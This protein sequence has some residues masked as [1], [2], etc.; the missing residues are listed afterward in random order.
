MTPCPDRGS[1]QGETCLQEGTTMPAAAG[2]ASRALSR[3]N[4][5]SGDERDE[6]AILTQTAANPANPQLAQPVPPASASGAAAANTEAV[7]QGS[8]YAPAETCATCPE[9]S[10][11]VKLG[12]T[13][14]P[15]QVPKG[16]YQLIP[17]MTAPAPI[18]G[19]GRILLDR[20]SGVQVPATVKKAR[21]EVK[22]TNGPGYRFDVFF[23]LPAIQEPTGLKR[24]LTNLGLYAGTDEFFGGRALW[25][26]RA[27]KRIYMN[28]FVRNANAAENDMFNGGDAYTI[29]ATIMAAVQT[30][31]GAHPADS[32]AALTPDEALLLRRPTQIADAGMFGSAVLARGSYESAGAADDS[33]P[34]PDRPRAVWGGQVNP[35][36]TVSKPGYELCLGAYD[37]ALGEAPIENCVNLPQ[38]IHM[39]QFALFETGY[40][41]VA[42]ARQNSRTI[43]S[44][45]TPAKLGRSDIANG[46]FATLDG[47]YGR[48]THWAMREFQCHAKMPRAAVE[49]VRVAAP[50]Y[51]ERLITLPAAET[52]GAAR[53]PDA[54]R[55]SGSLNADTAR[56]LQ[57]WLDH[58]YR[59]PVLIYAA[60]AATHLVPTSWTAENIW[61]YDDLASTA[62]RVFALDMSQYYSIPAVFAPAVTFSGQQI[63]APVALGEYTT[64]PFGNGPVSMQR[65]VWTGPESAEVTPHSMIGRGDITGTGL[66][67]DELSTFRVVRTVSHFE[68]NGFLDSINAYD[69]SGISLGPCHWTLARTQGTNPA[70]PREMGALFS[71][72]EANHRA[73][74]DAALGRFGIRAQSRWPIPIGASGTYNSRVVMQTE[75]GEVQL[76]GITPSLLENEYI[77]SWH[78]FQRTQMACRTIDGWQRAMWGFAR[79]R[80]RDILNHTFVAGQRTI[81]VG[82]YATSEK[83]VAMLLR[84][85]IITPAHVFGNNL[86]NALAGVPAALTGQQREDATRA[87]VLAAYRAHAPAWANGHAA[88]IN[89]WTNVPQANVYRGYVLNLIDP[90]L[91]SVA[92]SLN[93]AQPQP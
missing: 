91:S 29:P 7:R 86:H 46:R 1:Q 81:R 48:S 76:C 34:R 89:G 19:D 74:F 92:G 13:F 64:S 88:T 16:E 70:E 2:R 38:P 12:W 30:A 21:L 14:A 33:D 49:D 47:A 43:G 90:V 93:F 11:R 28:G 84:W 68:C 51:T 78:F 75:S 42:G 58:R 5:N 45:G 23:D 83:T 4:R 37:E 26:I 20:A 44:Y 73:G 52:T 15:D 66:G 63:Q 32:T 85:H 65:H 53:Y 18:P 40:W 3:C 80:I 77:K 8:R 67:A 87:A 60:P 57:S 62:P 10:L 36:M 69:N 59:C 17:G 55:V 41:L 56:A 31:H 54:G 61:Y 27:F 71:Y 25:A 50:L 82:D 35:E 22:I 39:L 24:R 79:I 72:A 9:R 6:G